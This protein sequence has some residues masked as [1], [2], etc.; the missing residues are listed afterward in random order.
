MRRPLRLHY[1]ASVVFALGIGAPMVLF[2]DLSVRA[3][4][5]MSLVL[6]VLFIPV[7]LRWEK[8]SVDRS[9]QGEGPRG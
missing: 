2:G 6:G 8:H 9:E 7:S 4:L 1:A 3:W 5:G